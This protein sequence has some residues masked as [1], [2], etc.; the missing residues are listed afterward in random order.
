M[1]RLRAVA[2]ELL[3]LFVEDRRFAGAIA[4]W[5]VASAVAARVAGAGATWPGPALFAGL[6]AILLVSVA[7]A[8][9]EPH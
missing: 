8:A 2:G 5:L 6:S 9:K 7:F 1:N 3:G 4:A